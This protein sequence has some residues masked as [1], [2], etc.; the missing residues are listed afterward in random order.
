MFNEIKDNGSIRNVINSPN[1]PMEPRNHFSKTPIIYDSLFFISFNTT[2]NCILGSSAVDNTFWEGTLLYFENDKELEQYN[3]CGSYIHSTTSDGKFINEKMIALADD[4]G[5]INVLSIDEDNSIRTTNYFR[6][7]DRVPQVDVWDN[8]SRILGCGNKSIYIFDFKS[9]DTKP[10]Q[11]YEWFH[12]DTINCVNTLKKDTNLFLSGGRDRLACIWDMRDPVAASLLYTNEFSSVTSI[13]WNQQDN[14][15][16]VTGTQAGDV[17]LLDKREPKEFLSVLYCFS[18]P[19]NR[20]CFK[21]SSNFAVCGDTNEVL[22]INSK[23]S[24]LDIVYRNEKHQG[25]VK[26]LAW[27]N[28]V[29]Y[30]CGFKQTLIKHVI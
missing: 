30:S 5:H 28:D 4:T 12:C 24:N 2:G 14:N 9:S 27:Y 29:L 16:I 23:T 7:A 25:H 15:Y 18:A 17:Y 8:S 22:I 6:L 1:R 26:G 21:D 19:V 20:I 10:L 3:Y 11:R 13:A